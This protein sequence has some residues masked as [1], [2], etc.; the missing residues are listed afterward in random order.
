MDHPAWTDAIE[1][2]YLHGIHGPV[3]GESEGE[4]LPVEGELP[5]ELFGAHLRNGPNSV[6]A[7]KNQYHWFDGDGMVHGVYFR[8]GS[9]SYRSRFVKTAGLA[10]EAAKGESIWPGVMGPFDFDA[11]R[12]YLKDTGNTDL[13][14]HAGSVLALWYLCGEPYRLD[15]RTLETLGVDDFGGKRTTTVSAHPKRDERTGE[16]VWF[17]LAEFEPPYMTY[18]VLDE[19]GALVHQVPIDLPGPRAPHDVTLTEQYT[20]LHGYAL[21][22][23]IL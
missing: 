13:I 20:I 6:H 9:A 8:D 5:A 21:S 19:Q 22:N 7:P 11:P 14:W 12:H 16:L 1:N 15:P 18:G 23:F 17:T 10:D 4:D 3:T 2:P